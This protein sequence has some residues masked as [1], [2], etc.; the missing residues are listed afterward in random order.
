MKLFGY[1]LDKNSA[2]ISGVTVE[3]KDERFQTL[4]CAESDKKGYYE[5]EAADGIYAFVIAVKD[6]GVNN[7]EYWCQNLDLRRD[8]RLDARFDKLEVYGLHGFAVKGGLN[9]LMV[10]FR[11][12]SLVKFQAG[13]A[14]I[15]PQIKKMCVQLDGTE[16]KIL[17]ANPVKESAGEQS[18][19]AWLIQVAN[20]RTDRNWDRLDIEIWDTEDNFGS[21]TI[22]N[23]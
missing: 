5:I 15:A 23:N 17:M 7:L 13:E 3:I 22:F 1:T 6:Y 12:M 11:P 14:D 8:Q 18:L 20:S 10:Y 16:A 9:A 21:A 19:S 4:Y 2:P